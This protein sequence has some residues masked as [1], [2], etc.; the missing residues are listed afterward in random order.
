MSI[1]TFQDENTER[2]IKASILEDVERVSPIRYYAQQQ[3]EI[4]KDVIKTLLVA[5]NPEFEGLPD[6]FWYIQAA[7]IVEQMMSEM[8][9]T[10]VPDNFLSLLDNEKKKKE[11]ISLMKGQTLD[12]SQLFALLV[13]A[14]AKGY[15]FS[16]YHYQAPPPNVD[17]EKMPQVIEVKE[18]GNVHS[19][20]NK[21][22]S[23][24]QMKSVV[25]QTKK[26]VAKVLDKGSE[27][28]CFYLT[29]RG[30]AGKE[31]GVQGQQPHIHYISDKFGISREDLVK[32]IKKGECPT[33]SV[34]IGI[35]DY[36]S[37]EH[38]KDE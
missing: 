29:F 17:L 15:L 12:P 14:E 22:L 16:E 37:V 8:A 7:K 10:K 21:G 27:W 3:I 1:Q 13:N 30:L 2:I 26:I 5:T 35:I 4:K 25:E 36:P 6:E 31:S 20:G 23:D 28:H 34:H 11:Q 19:I 33:S 9:N 32:S 24:G 18:N 38:I